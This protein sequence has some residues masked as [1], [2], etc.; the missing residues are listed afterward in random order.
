MHVPLCCALQC[1]GRIFPLE[2]HLVSVVPPE[3]LPACAPHGCTVVTAVLFELGAEEEGQTEAGGGNSS[4]LDAL[5]QALPVTEGV[6]ARGRR[7]LPLAAVSPERA[8]AG[9]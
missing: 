9:I 8:A 2:A 6:R 5:A 7:C 1:T 3:E 4:L